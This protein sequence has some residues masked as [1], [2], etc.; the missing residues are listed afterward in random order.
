MMMHFWLSLSSALQRFSFINTGNEP[1]HFLE[2]VHFQ[3]LK[4]TAM[5]Y[6]FWKPTS[7]FVIN[8]FQ[9][10]FMRQ[11][12]S[13]RIFS[14]LFWDEIDKQS[15]ETFVINSR[16]SGAF[17]ILIHHFVNAWSSGRIRKW[18]S[19]MILYNVFGMIAFNFLVTI[20]L[21]G[22]SILRNR[23]IS[24]RNQH[25]DDD[26]PECNLLMVWFQLFLPCMSPSPISS[27]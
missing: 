16:R 20:L 27:W 9:S 1:A 12:W 5:L 11:S 2:T 6:Y 24:N 15:W 8:N 23:H 7:V 10:Y 22:C 3:F 13:L 25:N 18:L 19:Y 21:N 4:Y 17:L 14:I 26:S